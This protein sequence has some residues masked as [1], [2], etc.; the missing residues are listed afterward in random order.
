MPSR[1]TDLTTALLPGIDRLYT[2]IGTEER[3]L[4]TQAKSPRSRRFLRTKTWKTHSN[5]IMF[6]VVENWIISAP[7]KSETM[8]SLWR[9]E[10]LY[11]VGDRSNMETICPISCHCGPPPLSPC[12]GLISQTVAQW[13]S[14]PPPAPVTPAPSN[15]SPAPWPP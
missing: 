2:L 5:L 8:S 6:W 7:S 4:R 15:D 3:T 13:V 14:W 12:F 11:W 1:F 9:T 10:R